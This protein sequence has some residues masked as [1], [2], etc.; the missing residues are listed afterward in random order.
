MSTESPRRLTFYLGARKKLA[1]LVVLAQSLFDGFWLGVFTR[2]SLH[3]LDQHCYDRWPEY[4]TESYNRR[5]L[6]DWEA[7]AI[8]AHFEGCK[9]LLVIGAGGGREVLALS[10]L[11]LEVDGYECHPALVGL[12]NRLLA[13]E[14]VAAR[15]EL[16]SR[17]EPPP[18][19]RTYD[20]LIVGW[21]AYMLIQGSEKRIAF[22][23]A[24]RRHVSQKA[25]ILLSFYTRDPASRRFQLIAA[26]GSAVRR[27]LGRSPVEPGDSLSPNYVHFFTEKEIEHE[28]RR[29][30][31]TLV[32]YRTD[33]YGYAVGL[34]AETTG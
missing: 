1:Q 8:R 9:R 14:E 32:A 25:P 23:A 7:R 21:G 6:T 22:L 28:L 10:R 17:D 31:F 12:A 30:G 13:A 20:G 5:G 4:H 15:V 11:G 16:L 27:V 26:V 19:R 29:A 34:A 18:A 24:L 2:E 3:L 33:E